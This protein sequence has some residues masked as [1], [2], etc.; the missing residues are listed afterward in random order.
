MSARG[1]DRRRSTG[2][3]SSCPS[4]TFRPITWPFASRRNACK[5]SG[6]STSNSP[7]MTATVTLLPRY[8]PDPPVEPAFTRPRAYDAVCGPCI[9]C[10]NSALFVSARAAVPPPPP[11][12]PQA[13][14]VRAMTAGRIATATPA[15]RR[16]PMPRP[17]CAF[18]FMT[19]RHRPGQVNLSRAPGHIPVKDAPPATASR[20]LDAARPTGA[21]SPHDRRAVPDRPVTLQGE[22]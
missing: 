11:P 6:W 19:N 4:A 1:D 14:R 18:L 21:L 9:Y 22:T 7:S 10:R 20:T 8:P 17:R 5:M 16:G 12:P 15:R 2:L 3:T 13:A